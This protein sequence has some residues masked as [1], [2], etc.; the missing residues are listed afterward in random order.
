M[1][2]ARASLILLSSLL[3]GQPSGNVKLDTP[4]ARAVLLVAEPH[5]A[6]PLPDSRMDRVLVFVNPGQIVLTDPSGKTESLALRAG[7]VRWAPVGRPYKIENTSSQAVQI[8][9][10]ELKSKP[11]R[12]PLPATKLDPTVVDSKHYKVELENDRVRVL[13]VRYGPKEAGTRHEHILNRVVC[14]I[15]DQANGKAGDVHISGAMTH[16]EEN[17][18]DRPV[19]R[20][21]V[22]LK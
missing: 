3:A 17:P 2:V 6:A 18:L 1:S 19:E 7:D 20:I 14:Y 21:A 22:E 16:S 9:A 4:E 8:I 5:Q 10:I 15:T 11:P 12:P 13:R